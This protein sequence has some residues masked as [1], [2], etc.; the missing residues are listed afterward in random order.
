M[1]TNLFL[2]IGPII[3]SFYLIYLA[4]KALDKIDRIQKKGIHKQAKVTRIRE[5]DNS[6][7]DDDG[8]VINSFTYYYTVNFND[9][10]GREI[11]KEIE[12]GINKKPNRNPPF[13]IGIIYYID[14]NKNIDIILKNSKRTNLEFY[15]LLGIG[16]FIL[17]FIAYNYDGQ[18]DI[19]LEFI[20]NLLK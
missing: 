1:N 12:F 14:E 16:I 17:S 4:I 18:I 6:S 11:E 7:E 10:N 5:E 3:F 20:N 9:K 15:S 13:S 19:I 2:F 8:Y